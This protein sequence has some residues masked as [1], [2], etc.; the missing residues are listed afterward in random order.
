[1]VMDKDQ[2]NINNNLWLGVWTLFNLHYVHSMFIQRLLEI[3]AVTSC[4]FTLSRRGRPVSRLLVWRCPAHAPCRSAASVHGRWKNIK[5]DKM[6]CELNR[7]WK[8][9]DVAYE[10][11][12]STV[13]QCDLTFLADWKPTSQLD[14]SLCDKGKGWRKE[15]S[16]DQSRLSMVFNHRSI[17]IAI[18]PKGRSHA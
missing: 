13:V 12:S 1:M 8:M 15:T 11:V 16:R 9:H 17:N 3:I 10:H 14:L 18:V 5:N 6:S 4:N 2:V 7:K